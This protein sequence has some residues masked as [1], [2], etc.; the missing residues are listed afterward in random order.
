[1]LA[2]L[3]PAP[4]VTIV[5]AP[6]RVPEG[7]NA[8]DALAQ[9]WIPAQAAELIARAAPVRGEGVAAA[10]S[11]PNSRDRVIDLLADAELWH[12]PER[13]PFATVPVNGH[14]E[15]HELGSIFFKD[16]LALSAYEAT[17]SVPPAE[18]IEAALRVARA[19]ALRSPCHRIWRRVAEHNGQIY[20]DFGCAHWRTVEIAATGWRIVDT[21]P[22]KFLRSRG[23]EALPEPEDGEMIELL[24]EFVNVESDTDFR[25]FVAFLAAALR[26]NGPFPILIVT[27]QAGSSKSTLAKIAGLLVDP[28]TPP[29]TGAPRDERDLFV[30]ASNCW[31]LS[32]SNLSSVTQWFSDALCRLTDGEGFKTRQLHSD[33]DEA[34]FSGARP[35]ILNGIGTLAKQ[36]DLAERALPISP[37]PIPEEKRREEREFWAAF[38]AS[39]PK[40]L[41]ALCDIVAGGL[42]RLPDVKLDRLPRRADFAR[43]G[44]ACAPGWGSDAAE[45]IADYKES[46]TEAMA[47]A[48]EGS[49]LLPPIEA[50]LA[51]TGLDA[52]GFDGTVT[53]LLK[54]LDD[55]CGETERKQKW[56]P[57]YASQLGS[58][59]SRA[60]PLL[61]LRGIE[62]QRYKLGRG[63]DRRIV[64]RC[65]AEA[66]YDELRA[67]VMGQK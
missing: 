61:R 21:V 27:G 14:R 60:A 66:A 15:N 36:P 54:R 31:L 47:A 42:M 33:R 49:L 40:M 48:A 26:P 16:W 65:T 37:P 7:W 35:I 20:L 57:K 41:G 50:V 62:F 46:R 17:G 13:I 4:A 39:R 52:A 64:L 34:I 51:R 58:A 32:Y 11:R 30:S 55:V 22:V 59:L 29:S 43:W 18:A 23:M 9:G 24:R 28:K 45:F 8:A 12:D 25:L 63:R 10:A 19:Q 1:M 5:K 2:K 53:E 56:F 6:D 44:A 3:S 38:E 67:R